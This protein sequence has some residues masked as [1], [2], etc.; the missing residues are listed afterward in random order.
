MGQQ[1]QQQGGGDNSLAPVWVTILVVLTAF[2]V[3]K[4]AH[5][6][7]VAFIFQI[8]ILQAQI[9]NFFIGSDV[10]SKEIYIMQTV[11]P[12]A[13]DWG[14]LI[15]LTESIGNYLRYPF[16]IV[17]AVLA[18]VLYT[19]NVT[20][21]Y[22]KTYSMKTLRNQEQHTWSA[23]MPVVKANL[24]EQDVNKGAWAMALSPM[25]FARKYKLLKKDDALLEKPVPGMEMTAGLKRADAK[26][27]FTLQLGPYWEG[28]ERD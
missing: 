16:I 27:V 15:M 18:Y 28:F 4:L 2:V 25:E 3:W 11:D 14:Q 6:Y 20:L 1:A 19:S 26:R 24:V 17:L 10:L 13:V 12:G 5:Q 21:K 22:R 23:I 7:I 8:N 9:I